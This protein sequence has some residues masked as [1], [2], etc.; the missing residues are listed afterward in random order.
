[1]S[2]SFHHLLLKGDGFFRGVVS[3]MALLIAFVI[4][5]AK[6]SMASSVVNVFRSGMGGRYSCSLIFSVFQSVLVKLYGDCVGV[7]NHGVRSRIVS[8]GR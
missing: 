1:M 2:S 3:A 6:L 5:A 8:I 4:F 7:V